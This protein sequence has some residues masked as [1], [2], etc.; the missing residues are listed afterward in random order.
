MFKK[1][2]REEKSLS[3]SVIKDLYGKH[4]GDYED[5]IIPK[6]VSLSIQVQSVLT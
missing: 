2:A 6:F 1:K 5:K 4:R 3:T